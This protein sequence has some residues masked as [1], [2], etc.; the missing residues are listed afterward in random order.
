MGGSVIPKA[1]ASCSGW[2][3]SNIAAGERGASQQVTLPP[4][5]QFWQANELIEMPESEQNAAFVRFGA[6]RADP[7][8]NPLKRRA[9]KLRFTLS[10]SPASSIRTARRIRCGWSLT[11]GTAMRSR[12]SFSCCQRI[13]RTVCTAS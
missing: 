10:A 9:A 4:F 2:K 12:G 13:R 11:N 8:A 1:K 6:F 5:A 7:Q 3:R